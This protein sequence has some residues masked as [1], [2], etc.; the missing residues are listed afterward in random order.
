M[1]NLEYESADSML[2]DLLCRPEIM[3]PDLGIESMDR[4]INRDIFGWFDF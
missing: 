2:A 3:D 4:H 1:A